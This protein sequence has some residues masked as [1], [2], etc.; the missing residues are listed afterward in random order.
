M[1]EK[2]EGMPDRFPNL[3]ASTTATK[4]LADEDSYSTNFKVKKFTKETTFKA[5]LKSVQRSIA[6]Q[7]QTL[8]KILNILESILTIKRLGGI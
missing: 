1:T 3:S 2:N 7:Q 5:E 8:N 6:M 4:E